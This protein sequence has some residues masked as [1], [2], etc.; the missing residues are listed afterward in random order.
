MSNKT[1]REETWG[2]SFGKVCKEAVEELE[3]SGKKFQKGMGKHIED[4]D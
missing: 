2:E 1:D 3:E 4:E